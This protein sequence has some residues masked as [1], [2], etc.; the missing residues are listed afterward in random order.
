MADTNIQKIRDFLGE[1]GVAL[2][3]GAAIG[4]TAVLVAV[5]RGKI[6]ESLETAVSRMKGSK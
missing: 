1:K 4:A 3:L 2:A 6:K 5:N